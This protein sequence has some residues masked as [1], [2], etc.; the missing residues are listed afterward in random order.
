MEGFIFRREVFII[1]RGDLTSEGMIQLLGRGILF[2]AEIFYGFGVF[3]VLGGRFHFQ[4][5]WFHF[6]G[7]SIDLSGEDFSFGGV[8]LLL[9]VSFIFGGDILFL[10]WFLSCLCRKGSF[11]G[12]KVLTFMGRVSFCRALV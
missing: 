12:E 9:G 8:C 1:R 4:K 2:L 7:Y 6:W 3:S 10:V 5:S 11:S